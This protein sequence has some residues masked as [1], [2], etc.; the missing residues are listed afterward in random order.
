MLSRIAENMQTAQQLAF[1]GWSDQIERLVRSDLLTLYDEYV[2]VRSG[3]VSA[4]EA[5]A[6]AP[7]QKD[8][9]DPGLPWV[10]LT[11]CVEE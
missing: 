10:S 8:L 4:L 2:K 11:G 5:E 1:Q 3:S 7:L 9:M 6:E